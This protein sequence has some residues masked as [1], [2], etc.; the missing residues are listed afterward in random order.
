VTVHSTDGLTHPTQEKDQKQ[1]VQYGDFDGYGSIGREYSDGRCWRRL[2]QKKIC[3]LQHQRGGS[4]G[5][6][7]QLRSDHECIA[8]AGVSS[9][10]VSLALASKFARRLQYTNDFVHASSSLVRIN[11][12]KRVNDSTLKESP[13][14][15]RQKF[16]LDADKTQIQH[17]QICAI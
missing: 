11:P 7:S 14:V 4:L 13:I 9:S 10:F 15:A 12:D 17:W 5:A 2:G 3:S 8:D 16:R 1:A 6:S